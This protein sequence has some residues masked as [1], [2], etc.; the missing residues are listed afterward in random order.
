MFVY[1]PLLLSGLVLW[2]AG[3]VALRVWGRAIL[4]PG[5]PSAALALFAVSFALMFLVA[6]RL[7]KRFH[8]ERKLWLEGT[9]ALVLPTL[10]LDPF[11]CAF[12]SSVFPNIPVEA[13]GLFGG[14]M[15][16]CCCG[17]LSGAARCN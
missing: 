8:I 3:T 9:V 4:H 7:C 14:W 17:A 2:I 16:C 11:S 12:F 6:R 5:S 1:K 10:L 15:L 13:A